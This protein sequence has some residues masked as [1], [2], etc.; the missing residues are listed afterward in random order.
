MGVAGKPA[1]GPVD[2]NL[3][4]YGARDLDALAETLAGD[5]VMAAYRGPVVATGRDAARE[6]YART[7][8]AYPMSGTRALN[9]IVFADVVVDHEVSVRADGLR[10]YVATLYRLR[11]GRIAR[12][13]TVSSKRAPTGLEAAQGQL[14]AYNA[15]DLGG[16]LGFFAADC[17][18]ADYQ[19]AVTQDGA[20]AIRA[21]YADA[22]KTYPK[23]HARLV[24]RIAVAGVVFDHEEVRRGPEGPVFEALAI[25]SVADGL[26]RR[27]EFV[28]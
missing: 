2:A 20:A 25:Y 5:V 19:G 28:K 3:A 8:E 22:F 9:R 21:R 11:D 14:D 26:I 12:I 27:V 23:N 17:A 18:I 1:S 7:I 24:N 6:A 13:E 10:R 15:Q 4:A 16:Y